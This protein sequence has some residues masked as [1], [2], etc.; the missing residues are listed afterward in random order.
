MYMLTDIF[1]G[2]EK[3]PKIRR[4]FYVFRTDRAFIKF[5]FIKFGMPV[6]ISDRFS[7]IIFLY[8]F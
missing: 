4:S 6:N 8:F 2:R 1:R 7:K 5:S 3:I